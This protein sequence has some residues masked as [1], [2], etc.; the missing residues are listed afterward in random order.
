MT[1]S[2]QL[3]ACKPGKTF[4]EILLDIANR[5]WWWEHEQELMAQ[6]ESGDIRERDAQLKA[7]KNYE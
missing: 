3:Y 4:A 5:I 1:P 2:I 6:P 7:E